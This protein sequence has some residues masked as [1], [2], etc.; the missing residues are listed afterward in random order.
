MKVYFI[1]LGCDKNTVETQMM[2][3]ILMDAGIEITEDEYEADACVINS[4]AFIADA[5]RESINAILE[6]ARLK[7][8]SKLKYIVVAGCLGQRYKDELQEQIPEVDAIVGINSFDKIAEVLISLEDKEHPAPLTGD[9]DK[10]LCGFRR[11]L[12]GINHSASLKIAEGCNKRCTYCAIPKIRGNYRSVPMEVLLKEAEDLVRN[13]VRELVIVAQETTVYG[14]DI[15]GRKSLP[16]L[17]R[18]LAL[19]EDLKMIRLMYCYPEE[20]TDELI[21]VMRDEPKVCHYIDIPIQSASDAVLKKMG[22]RT[23]EAS[24]REL[25]G[26]LRE[27]IPDIAIRTTLISG[28]PGEKGSD[29]R[30]TL[31]FVKDMRFDRLGVFAYSP[32][33]GT[34]AA[35]MKHQVPSFIKKIRQNSIMRLQQKIAYEKAAECKGRVMDVMIDGELP[36]DNVYVGRTYRD[37]QGIDGYIFIEKKRELMSGDVIRALVTDATGYDLLGHEV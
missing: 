35:K 9:E 7:E 26:R 12:T 21:E 8:E 11:V 2:L 19:I 4:C 3:G 24:I 6:M 13:G 16:E 22:R 27:A 17:I 33:E 1:S 31:Q 36:E 32:E 37:A 30:K 5:K 14:V 18:K 15:Y 10:V 34:P 20:I 25:I 23:D 28:F 29:H